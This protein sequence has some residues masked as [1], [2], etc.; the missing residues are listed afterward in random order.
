MKQNRIENQTTK[1]YHKKEHTEEQ[2]N[3]NFQQQ[4][5]N[6]SVKATIQRNDKEKTK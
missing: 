6:N 3:K 1:E 2:K 4:T 5:L